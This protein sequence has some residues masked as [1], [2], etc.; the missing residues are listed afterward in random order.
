[1]IKPGFFSGDSSFFH[2]G[3]IARNYG[4][5]YFLLLGLMSLVCVISIWSN[6]T[7]SKRQDEMVNNLLSINEVFMQVETTHAYLQDYYAYSRTTSAQQYSASLPTLELAV[8]HA[9]EELNLQY[10]REVMDLTYMIEGYIQQA[11]I[12]MDGLNRNHATQYPNTD[13]LSAQ[14]AEILESY[15]FINASFKAVYSSKLELVEDMQ[16]EINNL[17]TLIYFTV[18]LIFSGAVVI[19]FVFFRKVL[20]KLACSVNGLTDFAR[21][22]IQQPETHDRIEIVPT[23]EDEIV[24]LCN[25]FNEMLDTIH[26]QIVR[27][28]EDSTL[29]QQMQEVELNRMRIS[30]ALHRSQ[31]HLLQARINPHFLF[32]TLNMISKTAYMENAPETVTLIETTADLMRYNLGKLTTPVT[33]GA[34]IENIKDYIAIQKCRFGSRIQMKIQVDPLCESVEV[35]C[36]ILQPLVE[37]SITHGI[38][39]RIEG[40]TIWLRICRQENMVSIEVEDDGVGIDDENLDELHQRLAQSDAMEDQH[41]GLCNV[42][43]RLML[44]FNRNVEFRITSEK[45]RTTVSIQIFLE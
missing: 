38:S 8:E 32:N 3:S 24:L 17:Q 40:G 42:Y 28:E 44:Y 19:F 29:R 36:L 33:L 10:S 45:N 39:D 1:M 43:G 12:L 20:Q 37:N 21:S 34:E 26:R 5:G 14:Y 9:R 25:A 27:I 16:Q 22:V 41:I 2:K 7:L 13:N 15:S 11:Q 35:P 6:A 18:F 30:A 4:I 23:A 31:L